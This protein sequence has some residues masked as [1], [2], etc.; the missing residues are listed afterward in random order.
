LDWFFK[1]WV[2]GTG[3]PKLEVKS[4]YNSQTR[5][6]ALDIR[7]TQKTED[8]TPSAFTLP[9]VVE[10]TTSAGVV[11]ETI[12]I[13]KRSET[14]SIKLNAA[15]TKI[16]FDKDSKIPLKFVKVEEID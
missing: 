16:E 15:P 9:M 2:Y 7:Q 3:F 11:R 5:R 12:T 6:L 8:S 1:Q 4:R 14:F 13:S 10:I